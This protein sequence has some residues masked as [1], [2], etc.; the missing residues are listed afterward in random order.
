MAIPR[1]YGNKEGKCTCGFQDAANMHCAACGSTNI[2]SRM[3]SGYT[4]VESD[5]SSIKVRGFWCRKCGFTFAEDAVCFAPRPK[6]TG[7]KSGDQQI[8]DIHAKDAIDFPGLSGAELR[9]AK[10][11]AA[12]EK[13]KKTI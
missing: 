3:T 7:V 4:R 10:I 1:M 8:E 2:V 9:T 12:F 13:V 5:G 11:K 6:V